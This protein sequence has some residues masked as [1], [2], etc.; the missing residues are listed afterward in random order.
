MPFENLMDSIRED[1]RIAFPSQ[2]NKR[3]QPDKSRDMAR[4]VRRSWDRIY[5]ELIYLPPGSGL[6]IDPTWPTTWEEQ[7]LIS[8][9]NK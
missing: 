2:S 5:N 3:L 7:S 9:E 6:F 8:T 1:K 4:G